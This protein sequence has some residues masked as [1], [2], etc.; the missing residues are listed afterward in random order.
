MGLLAI[1]SLKKIW[2]QGNKN[3]CPPPGMLLIKEK[4]GREGERGGGGG[5]EGEEK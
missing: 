4:G 3:K 2:L 5:K 1:V